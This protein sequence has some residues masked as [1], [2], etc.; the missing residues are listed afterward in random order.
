MILDYLNFGTFIEIEPNIVEMI[1]DNGVELDRAKLTIVSAGF[2]EKFQNAPYAI[3]INRK[4]AFFYSDR[5]VDV[6]NDMENLMGIANLV[7]DEG[8]Q[9]TGV[10]PGGSVADTG[11]LEEDDPVLGEGLRKMKSRREARKAPA[12]EDRVFDIMLEP[13]MASGQEAALSKTK[14]VKKKKRRIKR[15]AREMLFRGDDL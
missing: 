1:I 11:S 7:V 14:T 15:P 5:S 9:E 8:E 6:Y 12:D 3:L 2:A 10:L 4:N 13:A